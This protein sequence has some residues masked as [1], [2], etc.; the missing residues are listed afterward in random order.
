MAKD[1]W[2]RRSTWTEL[3]EE[4]FFARLDRSRDRYHRAQYLRIQ[5]VHLYQ[6]GLHAE[7]LRLLDH[8]VG[9]EA[10]PSQLAWA[11]QERAEALEKVGRP[12]E[13]LSA[14]RSS[15]VSE[16]A[17]P[18]IQTRAPLRFARLAVDS[19]REDLYFEALDGIGYFEKQVQLFP[20]DRFQLAAYRAILLFQQGETSKASAWAQAALEVAGENHSGLAR[21]PAMG[22]VKEDDPLLERVADIATY[23]PDQG[24]LAAIEDAKLPS[25][26]EER[27]LVLELREA[28]YQ[29]D[30][31][32]D[33][34]NKPFPLEA[35]D[36]LG[37][38]LEKAKDEAFVEGIARALTD[39]RFRTVTELLIKKFREVESDSVRWAI[40]DSISR[41]RF[42][43]NLWEDLLRI[44]ADKRFGTG[45]QWIVARL[46]RIKLP[47]TE[48]LLL[49][50]LED[51]DV[52]AFAAGALRYC[53]GPQALERL[54]AVDLTDRTPL[55]KRETA[56]AIKK[57]EAKL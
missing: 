50:L 47:E 35:E 43:K 13:A 17:F 14:W 4:E 19:K 51:E 27:A 20:I 3:D 29:L 2:Y 12:A 8:L 56:K 23:P 44:A 26:P 54:H 46:H 49:Q 22:L 28:G 41:R 55:M 57:L 15:L 42:T 24:L 40:G 33:W 11:H 30:S 1:D 39:S 32:W 38:H 21:H 45:R 5:A 48:D 36:I 6:S 18:N 37:R 16:K 9:H 25:K 53:G 31:I 7:A 34:V 52:D 10:E